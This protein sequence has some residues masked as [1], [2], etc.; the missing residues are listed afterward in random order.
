MEPSLKPFGT[1]PLMPPLPIPQVQQRTRKTPSRFLVEKQDIPKP[2]ATLKKR[3]ITKKSEPTTLSAKRLKPTEELSNLGFLAE[4]VATIKLRS[5]NGIWSVAVPENHFNVVEN[6][7]FVSVDEKVQPP[8]Q[9]SSS[10]MPATSDESLTSSD[11]EMFTSPSSTPDLIIQDR[12]SPEYPIRLDDSVSSSSFFVDQETFFKMLATTHSSH[13]EDKDFNFCIQTLQMGPLGDLSNG[14]KGYSFSLGFKKD[15]DL[16]VEIS[17]LSLDDDE[18]DFSDAFLPSCFKHSLETAHYE[19]SFYEVARNQGIEAAKS[20]LVMRLRLS[21][22]DGELI[23]LH[24]GQLISGKELISFYNA[25][26]S[27]FGV[28]KIYICDDAKFENLDLDKCLQL[29]S[30]IEANEI[31]LSTLKQKKADKE[32]DQKQFDSGIKSTEKRIANDKANLSMFFLRI[33]IYKAFSTGLTY[34]Q[35]Y[36]PGLQPAVIKDWPR[37]PVAG[38]EGKAWS[39]TQNE[40]EYT[41]ALDYLKAFEL[42]DLDLF[43]PKYYNMEMPLDSI[44]KLAFDIPISKMKREEGHTLGGL[45]KKLTAKLTSLASVPEEKKTY[46]NIFKALMALDHM[47]ISQQKPLKGASDLE[48]EFLLRIS[49]I[50]ST[51]VYVDN[52]R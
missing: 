36:I 23:K 52:L 12:L 45:F 8:V 20:P 9:L 29:K 28:P 33:R 1:F 46:D 40:G 26:K 49:I 16:Q 15:V 37:V 31:L 24:K 13:K 19:I 4:P 25:L 5:T 10:A 48:T 3:K 17:P 41:R 35:Q 39:M 7:S 43:Y 32:I 27:Y 11:E 21:E 50:G 34:Y 44:F 51:D 6:R 38:E 42:Q 47:I 2:K 18:A 14:K 30:R 22:H